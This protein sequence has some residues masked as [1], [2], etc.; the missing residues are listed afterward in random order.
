MQSVLIGICPPITEDTWKGTI[1]IDEI[2]WVDES[3]INDNGQPTT[4][5]EALIDEATDANEMVSLVS[6]SLGE[7]HLCELWAS[8]PAPMPL[9]PIPHGYPITLSNKENVNE[10]EEWIYQ[11]FRTWGILQT[12]NFLGLEHVQELRDCILEEISNV[13]SMLNQH[14][15]ELKIG[16]DVFHFR[17]IASR[18]NER[19]DLVLS[20]DKVKNFIQ[21]HLVLKAMSL[22][23]QILGSANEIDYDISVV[24]SKPGAPIQGWHADGDHQKGAKDAGWDCSTRLETLAD[25]YAV[26]LFMPLIPLNEEVGYTQFWP[27][28]HRY[29]NLMGFGP[30][31]EIAGATWNGKCMAGDAIFYDYRLFHRGMPNKITSMTLRPVLQIVFKKKWYVEKA[32]YGTESYR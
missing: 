1:D 30:V 2:Q 20:G 26:C 16:K 27:G 4:L 5:V 3:L 15:P 31:A 18:G 23:E 14:K 19:F 10:K 28:S 29:R 12:Q 24:Y 8:A 6:K 21:N 25:P 22:L 17:E 9:K 13:E 7:K 32:N 11:T